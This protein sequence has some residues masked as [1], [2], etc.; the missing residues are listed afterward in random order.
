M[1]IKIKPWKIK[2]KRKKQP[3]GYKKVV[4][5]NGAELKERKIMKGVRSGTVLLFAVILGVSSFV[6][7]YQMC[8]YAD[9]TE[10]QP[11]VSVIAETYVETEDSESS[12]GTQSEETENR[13]R[14]CLWVNGRCKHLSSR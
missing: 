13:Q 5:E 10:F 9:T 3:Y 6:A 2:I 12:E 4:R 11:E 8:V 7:D 1:K 14:T